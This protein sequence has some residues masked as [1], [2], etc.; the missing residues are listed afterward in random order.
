M[1]VLDSN[2]LA[3]IQTISF[4]TGTKLNRS[5]SYIFCCATTRVMKNMDISHSVHVSET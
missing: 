2:F 3:V 4:E 5:R 1:D